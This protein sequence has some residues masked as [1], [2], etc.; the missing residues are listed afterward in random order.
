MTTSIHDRLL[1]AYTVDGSAR[2]IV[3]RTEPHDGGGNALIN[4]TFTGVI[5]Y[6]FEGDCLNNVL[7]GIEEVA[8]KSVIGDGTAFAERARLYGCP[9]GWNPDKETPEEFLA[10]SGCRVFEIHCS[11]G[12]YGWVAAAEMRQSRQERST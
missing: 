4:V 1:T 12:M 6:H 11:Y 5:A 2:Q 9:A 10:R 8:P 7:F 3:L